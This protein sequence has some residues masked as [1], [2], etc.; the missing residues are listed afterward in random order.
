M[1]K[2]K[3]AVVTVL[4][5]ASLPLA[6]CQKRAGV[7]AQTEAEQTKAEQTKAEQTKAA[8]TESETGVGRGDSYH[9]LSHIN[10]RCQDNKTVSVGLS[11]DPVPEEYMRQPSR[12]GRLEKFYYETNTY[13]LYGREEEKIKK[14]A[15][16]YLPYGYD[17]SEKY[18]VIYLM[19]GAGGTPER[20]FGSAD[21][22]RDFKYIVDNMI[23]RGSI[24]PAIFVS[25]TYY[26]E[27]GMD[28]EEDWDAQYTKYYYQELR[29]DVLP[30]VESHYSTYAESVDEQGLK[31]SRWH[32]TFGGFSMGGVT[33]F[34]RLTDC[35]DYFHS[36]LAMSGSLYWG[37]DAMES[38]AGQDFGARYI[39]EA[40]ADQ[41]YT[42]DD[43]FLYTCTG[44]KDFARD[45]MERQIAGQKDHPEFFSYGEDGETAN[46]AFLIADGE[47][48]HGSHGTN[49]YLYNALPI[50]SAIMGGQDQ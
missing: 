38:G 4:L 19:H 34:Y 20:F 13:G 22:P 33:A 29:N 11:M 3:K 8:Q 21:K 9:Y 30:Q 26:P 47:E 27:R 42:K 39:M 6:A 14:Y 49:R 32:R 16:V 10:V 28:H 35:L 23:D 50:F 46:T 36:F 15:E 41:G 2:I 5:L 37:P 12:H 43:F 44:S 40:A 18:N 48:H 24:Q 17:E 7:P 45:I 1:N 31:D 25:L